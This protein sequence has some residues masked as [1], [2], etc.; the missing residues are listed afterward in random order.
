V[1]SAV[2]NLVEREK[3]VYTYRDPCNFVEIPFAELNDGSHPLKVV[4]D[5]GGEAWICYTGVDPSRD[6]PD[7]GCWRCKDLRFD[8][9][10]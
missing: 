4:V 3:L 5:D 1:K 2:E 6:L 8:R 7:Q 9:S 10:D